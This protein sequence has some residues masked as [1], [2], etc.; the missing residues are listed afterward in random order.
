MGDDVTRILMNDMPVAE[1]FAFYLAG[2]FGALVWFLIKTLRSISKDNNTPNKF[3]WRYVWKG[4]FKLLITIIILPWVVIY[5]PDYGPFIM[6]GLFN[7][8]QME[9]GGGRDLI[10]EMNAGS[11]AIMGFFLDAGIRKLTKGTFNKLLK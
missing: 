5:F 8:P 4:A 1:F 3:E 6:E 7:F 9:E 10:M 11:A 2:L